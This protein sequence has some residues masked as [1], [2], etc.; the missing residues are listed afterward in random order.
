MPDVLSE[1]ERAAIAAYKGKVQRIPRGVSS[2]QS[3]V[4]DEAAKKNSSGGLTI[5]GAHWKA[6]RTRLW[7]VHMRG[8]RF[9]ALKRRERAPDRTPEPAMVMVTPPRP[10]AVHKPKLKRKV[11]PRATKM[12]AIKAVARKR[13]VKV[14][15]MTLAGMSQTPIAKALGVSQTTIS[16]DVIHLRKTGK[17]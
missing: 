13:Q 16:N 17:L 10:D 15:A 2:E 6:E 12:R 9:Q 8:K 7:N 11:K 1:H 4:Y 14:L 5:P 3:Y